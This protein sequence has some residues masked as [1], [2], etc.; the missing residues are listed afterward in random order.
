M[1]HAAHINM[2]P[3]DLALDK[4]AY[5]VSIKGLIK[6]TKDILFSDKKETS[7]DIQLKGLSPHLLRDIG[8]M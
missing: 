4:K 1:A 8:M 3:Q 6:H 5:A 2:I 7:L